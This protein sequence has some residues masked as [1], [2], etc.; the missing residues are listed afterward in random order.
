MSLE[1]NGKYQKLDIITLKFVLYIVLALGITEL[2]VSYYNGYMIS[3]D[4]SRKIFSQAIDNVHQVNSEIIAREF[5]NIKVASEFYSRLDINEYRDELWSYS[6]TFLLHEDILQSVFYAKVNGD[7]IQAAKSDDGAIITR[8]IDS[9]QPNDDWW[10][11]RGENLEL[12]RKEKRNDSYN[13]LH[14]PWFIEAKKTGRFG[15]TKL[16]KFYTTSTVGLALYNPIYKSDTLVGVVG[17]NINSTTIKNGLI[18]QK[19]SKNSRF[20]VCNHEN[21]ILL[22]DHGKTL[23]RLVDIDEL[24]DEILVKAFKSYSVETDE[25][26]HFK[27]NGRNFLVDR[28]PIIENAEVLDLLIVIPE[29]DILAP[30]YTQMLFGI[31]II[32]IVLILALIYSFFLSKKIS[33]PINLLSVQMDYL[34]DF[35]LDNIEEVRTNILEV[36]NISESLMSAVS[37]LQSFKKYLP[38]ELVNTLLTNG[39]EADVGGEMR[40]LTIMFTDIKDFST[41]S[42]TISPAHLTT[43]LSEYLEIMTDIISEHGGTVDKFLGDGILAFWGAPKKLPNCEEQACLAAI[44]CQ[45]ELRKVNTFWA[46]SGDPEMI[47]RI[48]IHSGEVTVGNIGTNRKL[49]YTV[50]GDVVNVASRIEGINKDLGTDILIS[51]D[52]YKDVKGKF[53]CNY[54][55]NSKIRGRQG[56]LKLYELEDTL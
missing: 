45:Q 50:V 16:Y 49:E 32:V 43:H 14:E 9:K 13:P 41:I 22:T 36:H 48:G 38:R 12:T 52:V 55:R 15:R 17:M 51:E 34:K 18:P 56:F 25:F 24:D 5:S 35:R 11:F 7:F 31:V 42:E 2:I 27:F 19:F 44:K 10:Y 54:M 40:K 23:N 4:L 47:T 20:L 21:R 53:N 33:E 39:N 26:T 1:K 46:A 29:S 28:F 8:Y 3:Y 37:G 6:S 30:V